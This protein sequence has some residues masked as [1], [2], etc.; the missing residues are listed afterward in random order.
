MGQFILIFIGFLGVASH[1][2]IK[3]QSL[4][5]DAKGNKVAFDWW[6]DYITVDIFSIIFSFLSVFIW[7]FL[8]G[9]IAKIYPGIDDFVRV[10]FFVFGA[11]G[12]YAIQYTLG[13][14]KGL[15]R[16]AVDT[17]NNELFFLLN[18]TNSMTETWEVRFR[19]V[20]DKVVGDN[21]AGISLSDFAT[22]TYGV[23]DGT[24]SR[25]EYASQPSFA[26]VTV[27]Q[28]DLKTY[29]AVPVR[30]PR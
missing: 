25:I 24:G 20:A 9:E 7:F 2:L 19:G 14:A 23:L 30:R 29:I 3:L 18:K 10:S 27:L 5:R 4:S 8:F 15:I 17:K 13:K 12:S 6:R 1:S 22:D 16:Q 28:A 11:V 26:Q 21:G